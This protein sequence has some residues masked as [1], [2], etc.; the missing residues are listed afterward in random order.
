ML[1]TAT[2]HGSVSFIEFMHDSFLLFIFYYYFLIG[3]FRR[4]LDR[5][6]GEK[7]EIIL[8]HFGWYGGIVMGPESASP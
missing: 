5:F 2:L 3:W 6:W 8:T 1:E 7:K 4:G